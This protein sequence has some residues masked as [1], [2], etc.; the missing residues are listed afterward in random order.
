M[1]QSIGN[2]RQVTIEDEMR[3]AYL[4]YAMSVIVQRALP[5]VRDGLKPV[6]RRILHAMNELGLGAGAGYRKSATIVGEV[7]GKYHPHGDVSVYD[8]LVRLA[9]DFSMRH[10]LV[11][12]QG[13]FG[14]VDGDPPAAYRYTEARMTAIAEE[15]LRDIDR[16]TVDFVP[17]YDG[18]QEEPTVLPAKLP[19]LLL[20]GS[21]GI[22]VGM[23]T[24]IPPHNLRELCDAIILL[25]RNAE[26]TVT[27]L[28]EIV[29]GPD[30]PTGGTLFG[31]EGIRNAY[32]T[33][34]GRMVLRA[35]SHVEELRN[36]RTGIIVT[37]LPFQ[38]N[39]AVL[40]ERIA[41]LVNERRI[42]GISNINDESD[43]QGM[44][45]VIEL[46]R[47]AQVDAVLNSLYKNSDLQT[48]YSANMLAL[49]D[50]QPRVLS[51][52][53]MLRHYLAHRR[54]VVTRR[55]RYELD[56]QRRNA[57]I[58][59]GRAIALDNLDAVITLIR[60]SASSAVAQDELIARFAL[61]EVQARAI[62]ELTLSRLAALERQ[63]IIDELADVRVRV[64]DLEDILSRPARVDTIIVDELEDL[65]TRFGD[66]RRTRI[67][68]AEVDNLTAA[69]LI[70]P[71][72]V[73]V[74]MTTKGYIK[75]VPVSTY[76]AQGR[77]G[78]GIVG[79]VTREADAVSQ[80]FVANTHDNILF[81]TNKGRAFQLKVYELP[82][83]DRTARGVPVA[84][85]IAA[86]P[87]ERVSAILTLPAG[88]TD[89]YIVMATTRGTVK[90]TP[91]YDFRNV[92]RSGLIAIG[93]ADD[94]E[95]AWVQLSAGDEDVMLVTTD[96]RAIRFEQEDVRS[97]GR[98]A[99]GVRGIR[100]KPDDRVVAMGL[101]QEQGDLLVVTDEGYGKRTALVE[102]PT[103]GRGGGGVATIRPDDKI[104][105]IVAAAV[106]HDTVGE[107]I[108]MSGGGKIIRQPID[109]VPRLGRAT[110]GVRLMRLNEG[111]NV[112]SMAFLGDGEPDAIADGLKLS[113]DGELE[114]VADGETDAITD[115]DYGSLGA[116]DPDDVGV[117]APDSLDDDGLDEGGDSEPEF[118]GE[119]L[120]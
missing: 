111:D 84:N 78:K 1:E 26:A 85:V 62:L 76:R 100:L 25:I 22:A 59:E 49:V 38:V 31:A 52:D 4:D 44:R 90:R 57:H 23:A 60:A 71:E 36:G 54:D 86:E 2:V 21:D 83:K 97:M 10:R 112:V 82:D 72:D 16:G 7:L 63:K 41:E 58:L 117:G 11:D 75:R 48:A 101:V 9:Q 74:T 55:T 14:S 33:G 39:K 67:V 5:D 92:R 115:G 34:R 93:L 120:T 109:T 73:V 3:D 104:G 37:E 98:P 17:N 28:G 47:D 107:M 69:D 116:G 96:G 50:G 102:Y 80:L 15:M 20:N 113:G 119:R 13:N 40:Q 42:E 118:G 88:R 108:L 61:S 65:K 114:A 87:G 110:K 8:A 53:Q 27:E 99:A 19:Q 29:K 79:M 56:R 64:A 70:A 94:D 66:D 91:L 103:H 105:P 35:E 24:R 45:L 106:T 12:G 18:R 46:K 68:Q 95:L 51:L 89:G 32:A 77:G 81:F 43:R 30:F 6:H